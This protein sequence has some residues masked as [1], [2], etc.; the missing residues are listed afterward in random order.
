MNFSN[1]VSH[2]FENTHRP[3]RESGSNSPI[4]MKFYR[5]NKLLRHFA[6]VFAITKLKKKDK[7]K[8]LFLYKKKKILQ[9][10]FNQLCT[11]ISS[12]NNKDLLCILVLQVVNPV[13]RNF[14]D[15]LKIMRN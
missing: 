1:A 6:A 5:T 8:S 4:A 14:T 11:Y 2:R 9:Y 7:K 3:L 15:E 12:P 10:L 13:Y